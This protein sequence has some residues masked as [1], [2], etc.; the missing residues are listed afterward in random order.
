MRGYKCIASWISNSAHHIGRCLGRSFEIRKIT[1]KNRLFIPC[2][3]S[4]R[5][6]RRCYRIRA[7]CLESPS[8]ICGRRLGQPWRFPCALKVLQRPTYLYTFH[9]FQQ[10][11]Q[12]WRGAITVSTFSSFKRPKPFHDPTSMLSVPQNSPSVLCY[13]HCTEPCR[14]LL[15]LIQPNLT[16][17]SSGRGT[18]GGAPMLA[19]N[20][21]H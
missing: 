3:S 21:T 14:V 15:S 7:L 2:D 20:W 19:I 10:H 11:L 9:L 4:I 16:A 13:A 18:T 12:P 5:D 8:L 17:K 1:D 6:P